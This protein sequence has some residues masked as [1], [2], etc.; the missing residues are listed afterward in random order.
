LDGTAGFVNSMSPQSVAAG[1]VLWDSP[2]PVPSRPVAARTGRTAGEPGVA[3][4][5]REARIPEW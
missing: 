5:L 2:G 1:F 4:R 3:L